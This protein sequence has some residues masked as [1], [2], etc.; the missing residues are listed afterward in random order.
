MWLSL[1]IQVI[2]YDYDDIVYPIPFSEL[3]RNKSSRYINF[4]RPISGL[5]IG[6]LTGEVPAYHEQTSDILMMTGASD[7]HGLSSFNCLFSVMSILRLFVDETLP[8][9]RTTFRFLDFRL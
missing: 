3:Y 9:L 7:N 5:P 2:E 8:L 4:G 1:F 6:V